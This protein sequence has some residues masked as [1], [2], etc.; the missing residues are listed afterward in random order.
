MVPL[1][2]QE[3]DSTA[4][5][6]LP[7]PASTHQAS[8]AS[9][10]QPRDLLTQLHLHLREDR[11]LEVLEALEALITVSTA[12]QASQAA[13]VATQHSL[14]LSTAL[15]LLE[16]LQL[17]LRLPTRL[18]TKLRLRLLLLRLRTPT[19]ARSEI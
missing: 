13:T 5:T 9:I 16:P 4:V 15:L 14:A 6:P 8:T 2:P 19:T 7:T 1:L 18:T 17:R 11:L 12:S 3:E 10:L